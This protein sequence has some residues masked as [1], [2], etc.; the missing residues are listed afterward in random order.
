I[1]NRIWIYEDRYNLSK[2]RILNSL[3]TSYAVSEKAK[4][5]M[6]YDFWIQ[7]G[8]RWKSINDKEPVYKD[9][10][11]SLSLGY[12]YDVTPK[13]NVTPL[14]SAFINDPEFSAESTFLQVWVS[15]AIK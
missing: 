3:W 9:V 1:V 7:N 11:Q 2:H 8:N 12:S 14:L 10:W 13:L 4:V 15:Y 6:Y 5:Q